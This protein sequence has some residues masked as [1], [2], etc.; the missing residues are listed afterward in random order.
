MFGV[1][2]IV[3]AALLVNNPWMAGR[4]E[5]HSVADLGSAPSGP[6][7]AESDLKAMANANNAFAVRLYGQLAATEGNLLFS[8]FSIS[9]AMAMTYTGARDDTAAEIA[10]ALGFTATPEQLPAIFKSLSMAVQAGASNDGSKLAIANGLC[11]T[12]GAVDNDFL[13]ILHK[14]FDAE[15]FFGKLAEINDW[16]SKKTEGKIE[17]ILEALSPNSVCVLLN[18][19]YFKGTWA[20]Q[21]NRDATQ[22]APF[23][24]ATGEEVMVPL[25]YQKGDF[26]LLEEDAFQAIAMPYSGT[27][28]SMVLILPK[29]KGGLVAV[30]QALTA[31]TLAQW[32]AAIDNQ[33]ERSTEVYVPR[34]KL[35]TDFDLI[36]P[37][38]ALGIED[39][40]CANTNDFRGMG[41]PPGSLW[42]SQIKHKVLVEVNEEGTEAAGATAVEL[43]TRCVRR[44][45]V[46]RADHPFVFLIR[47][48]ATG[49][50]LFCG[51]VSDP[52]GKN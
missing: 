42:I 45:P 40:F 47:D 18:A 8:P 20:S 10:S 41:W 4:A 35:E 46:F 16:V 32:L 1:I 3:V 22:D 27:T 24:L 26:K 39:A 36:P 33:P 51:R 19:I 2:P 34:F 13:A 11:L 9:A 21:F 30:E 6:A 14:H 7:T 50:I 52:T 37:F 38:K 49:S 23:H 15:I 43:I 17:R 31:E 29:A 12:G 28:L 5:S 48:L 44:E 25:M